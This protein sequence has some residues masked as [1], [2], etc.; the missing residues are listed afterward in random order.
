MTEILAIPLKKAT[1]IDITKSLK[2]LISSTYSSADQPVDCSDAI[3]D[4]QKMRNAATKNPDRSEAS[5]EA[6][7]KYYDQLV[8]LEMK[9]PATEVQ[10]P[11]KWKDAFDKGSIFGGRISLTVSSLG[12]EKVCVLFNIAAV[13]TMIAESQNLDSEE[14]LQKANKKLQTA[15]GILTCL[16]E[17]VVGLMEQEPTPDLE[18]ECLAVLA[19][20]CLAQAQ[21]MVVQKAL[22]DKMKDNIVAKLSGHADDLFAEVMKLM[23]KESVRT[24]WDKDW[25][26]IISGKQA[27]YNG[28]AQYHQSKVCN[29]E[30]SVGEEIARLQFSIELMTACQT[31][32]GFAGLCGAADW[33]KRANRALT[34][35][36]KDNDF[37]YHERIPD[38]KT[39]SSIGRASVVKPT[40]VPEKFLPEEKELFGALMP[41][42]I[43]QALAAYDVRKQELVSKEVGRLK[44]GTN[45]LNDILTSMNLPAAL[46]DTTGGGVPAS[47]LE[48]SSAVMEVGGVEEL[49]RLAKELPEL[50]QR[51]TELLTEAE[52]MLREEQESDSS[53]RSQH[54]TRWNRTAS[55]KLTGTFTTNATKYRTIIDNART[56][57]S[58][59]REKMTSHLTGM[60]ALSG[61]EAALL[62][63]LP[64]G[65]S[66]SGGGSSAARL[67]QLME[68]VETVKAER[69][70][71]ES[72]LKGT[73]P[74]MKAV[75]LQAAANGSL[76]EPMISAQSLG[77]AFGPLQQQVTDSITRQEQII[78]Q[79]QDLYQPFIQERGGSGGAREEALKSIASAYDAFMELKG[80]LQEGTKFYN[81]LT[82]LLV[83]FQSKVSDFCFARKTEK[84]ELLKDLSSSL[85]N[86]SMDPPP[87]APAHHDPARPPR[88]TDP[89][90]RPPPPAVSGTA[91]P[92]QAP[93]QA[94]APGPGAANPYAGAPGPLP[95]PVQPT[96]SMPLPYQ[97]YT[98]L[99][100]G[101]NP[102]NNYQAGYPNPP[103]NPAY[104]QQAYYQPPYGG[105][106]PPQQGYPQPQYGAPPPQG[107]PQQPGYPPN[108]GYPQQPQWR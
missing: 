12:Y 54:G 23:Q 10:I 96:P 65:S 50:L 66:G 16:K 21:E 28:L 90:A 55:D 30:K 107:Y 18:P 51:N 80:N 26:P 101:Y 57:D 44:E 108:P 11:F 77:K 17:R 2:N 36:K 7:M 67:K 75:F 41:V 61:G 70:V 89:P 24:L 99:P 95:Y 76:N 13:S 15:A 47:L 84:E 46:E 92:A 49:E 19:S 45:M 1:D 93:A 100:G 106:P 81:D 38:F 58:V 37:I 87:E 102:Y 82:Q 68:D 48:K 4:L 72:E 88:K 79:V 40:A 34:D 69:S 74:D 25:L 78:A 6:M 98:P 71:V 60:K 35:A 103:A 64:S 22:K 5:V 32:A 86:L 39:L 63:L 97:P 59:V 3:S 9:I 27:F 29:A 94:P 42:H 83:T 14:G 85:S 53:L 20:L 31:R 43:H 56:A 104:P 73:N 33:I 62:S 91:P 52:R 105:G 8:S